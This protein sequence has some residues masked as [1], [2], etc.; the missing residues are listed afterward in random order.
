MKGACEM[1]QA[2]TMTQ[3]C[4][5]IEQSVPQDGWE[6]ITCACQRLAQALDVIRSRIDTSTTEQP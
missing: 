1:M 4:L 2:T 5:Q 6:Q 3:Q